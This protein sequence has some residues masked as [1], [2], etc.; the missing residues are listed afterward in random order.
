MLFLD[1]EGAMDMHELSGE[2]S[3]WLIDGPDTR[4]DVDYDPALAFVLMSPGYRP[5]RVQPP[6]SMAGRYSVH[7]V[8]FTDT[9]YPII[10]A[11]IKPEH[12]RWFLTMPQ[13]LVDNAI[14]EIQSQMIGEPVG[15]A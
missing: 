12:V 14:I 3:F 8:E 9:P 7:G 13:G 6:W 5:W 2:A 4:I 15:H 10:I 11:A 1:E